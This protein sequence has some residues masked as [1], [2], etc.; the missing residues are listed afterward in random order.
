MSN[1]A[2]LQLLERMR[3]G[4]ITVHG[5]RSTFKEWAI[6]CTASPETVSEMALAHKIPNKVEA[7]YPPR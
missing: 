7:A 6:E 4:D 2:M 5:F 1:G 3:R